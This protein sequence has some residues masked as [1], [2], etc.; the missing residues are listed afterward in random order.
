MTLTGVWCCEIVD[1]DS[2]PSKK[3][4]KDSC[5][6]HSEDDIHVQLCKNPIMLES[7]S[8]YIPAMFNDTNQFFTIIFDTG[9]TLAISLSRDDLIDFQP[10]SKMK[11]G[12]M[13]NGISIAGYGKVYLTFRQQDGKQLTLKTQAY[14]VP[15]ATSCLLS[16]QRLFDNENGVTGSFTGNDKE[17]I[18]TINNIGSLHIPYSKANSLPI[19][20]AFNSPDYLP[21]M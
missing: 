15:K 5:A 10:T 6:H 9:A 20:S 21:A 19:A 14:Y 1:N 8:M 2:Y 16:P 18:I 17:L 11:R 7:I 12:R 13:A 4:D 3:V